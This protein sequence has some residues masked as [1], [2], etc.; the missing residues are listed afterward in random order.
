MTL[1]SIK[2]IILLFNSNKKIK[3][4]EYEFRE[5]DKQ[6]AQYDTIQDLIERY[7]P[8]CDVIDAVLSLIDKQCENEPHKFYMIHCQYKNLNNYKELLRKHYPNMI[9]KGESDNPNAVH[10]WCS[11]KEDFITKENYYK[12]HF[13]MTKDQ[14]E[15]F[16]IVFR[17]KI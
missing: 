6:I 13:N 2:D 12:N 16:E 8:R 3:A 9:E 7:V 4:I 14:E 10:R 17:I 1:V 15:L 11:F 5:K